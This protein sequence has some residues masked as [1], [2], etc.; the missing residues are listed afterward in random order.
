MTRMQL[1]HRHLPKIT[2]AVWSITYLLLCARTLVLK[3]DKA[4]VYHDFSTAGQN[5][6]EGDLLYNRLGKNDFRYSPLVAAF[7]APFAL[8]PPRLGEFLWRSLNFIAFVSGL[9]YCCQAGV[10]RLFS[11][12]QTSAAFLL[13]LPLAIGSLNNAQSN[14]LVLG[15]LLIAAAAVVK[16]RWTVCS[17][18]ITLA[19]CFKLYPIAFGLLLVVLYPR[20]LGWRLFVGLAT[21]AVLPFVLQRAGYVMDQYSIWVRYLST[22]DRQRGPITDWYRDFRALWHVYIMPMS[23]T[24]YMLIELSTAGLIAVT[25]LIAR[26]RRMPTGLLVAFTLS[27]ACCWMTV[28]GPATE[29]PT[30]ILVAPA[31]AWGIVLSEDK[32]ERPTSDVQRPTS[33]EEKEEPLDAVSISSLQSWTLDVRRSTF[34]SKLTRVAYAV[35]FGIFLISQ[36]ALNVH[37][38]GKLFRDR[39]QP[40]PFAGV[41]LMFLVWAEVVRWKRES[42]TGEHPTSNIQHPTSK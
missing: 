40:L 27:L 32:G 24:T 10:P 25:V 36:L 7:F 12:Y 8:L 9:Y 18:A 38:Y 28:L 15:L 20:R 21:A 35:V 1:L 4:S 23:Q 6:L 2:A 14:P 13:C 41:I 37:I 17:I 29:S 16:E 3:V 11:K 30:Y 19:T 26:L 34:A 39:L 22:E 42:N 5:W 33:K 31:I